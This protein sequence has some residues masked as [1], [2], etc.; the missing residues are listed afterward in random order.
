MNQLD[1]IKAI[2]K[3]LGTT[4]DALGWTP[5]Y[6]SREYVMAVADNPNPRVSQQLAVF[7]ALACAPA[8]G[9]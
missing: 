3:R 6:G 8:G 9:S 5:S 4:A 2:A 1:P 7:L